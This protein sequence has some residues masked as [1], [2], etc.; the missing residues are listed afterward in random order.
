MRSGPLLVLLR[1]GS[2]GLQHRAGVAK[3]LPL[4]VGACPHGWTRNSTAAATATARLH[5]PCHAFCRA[6]SS[7]SATGSDYTT[8][9]EALSKATRVLLERSPPE[10]EKVDEELARLE[11]SVLLMHAISQAPPPAAETVAGGRPLRSRTDL[12]ALWRHRVPPATL[13]LYWDYVRRRTEAE[14]LAYITGRKQFWGRDFEV[15]EKQTLIPRP[16]SETLIECAVELYSASTCAPPKSILDLGTGTGCLLLSLLH[17]FP[18]A[19]G[20][21]ID[22][23]EV[24]LRTALRNADN[25]GLLSRCS[26]R[27]MDWSEH[28][29]S[30]IPEPFDLIVSNPPYIPSHDIHSLSASVRNYEPRAA[31]DGGDDGLDAYR[32]IARQISRWQ[33][34]WPRQQN[35]QRFLLVEVGQGQAR[36]VCQV[37]NFLQ[38][39]T[40]K[41]DLAGLERCVAF[42]L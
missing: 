32:S 12:L 10:G 17:E 39:V 1:R 9:Q 33:A 38:H 27:N 16:D 4:P 3:G 13:E 30:D 5:S 22:T 41:R 35:N 24:A 21:G 8:V 25:H 26:F 23:N 2:G 11:A 36:E 15:V 37:F 18:T 20:L 19:S 6:C 29:K 31:L 14:P 7:S 34:R 40:T 42:Q 28:G